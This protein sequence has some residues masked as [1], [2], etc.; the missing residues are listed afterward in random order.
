MLTLRKN[1]F[2]YNITQ[3]TSEKELYQLVKR[4]F[5]SKD[6]VPSANSFGERQRV[7]AAQI[8]MTGAMKYFVDMFSEK[9][10]TAE[11]FLYF[12]TS[13]DGDLS[14]IEQNMRDKLYGRAGKR[15]SGTCDI[16]MDAL[17]TERDV[18]E[19]AVADVKIIA[20]EYW[21]SC[22]EVDGIENMFNQKM[23]KSDF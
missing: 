20:M 5:F 6:I 16:I 17:L 22:D 1:N 4:L 2:D 15:R 7:V 10:Q 19:T 13:S 8:L 21:L 9:N 11:E 18:L 23:K 12:I 14:Y 3:E